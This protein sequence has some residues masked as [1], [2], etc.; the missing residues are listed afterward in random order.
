VRREAGREATVKQLKDRVAVITGGGSGIGA[1]LARACAGAGMRVVVADLD[2]SRAEV[3]AESI[4]DRAAGT[5]AQAV[6]VAVPE[7]V[8][9]LADAVYAAFGAAHLL[10]N[11]AGVSPLGLT[12]ELT[13]ADWAWVFGVNLF[14]VAN[15]IRSFVPRMIAGGE[16]GHV[17][18]TASNAALRA[19]P[20]L[21]AYTASKHAVLGLSD[22]LRLDLASSKIGVS[23]L[24]PGGVSTNIT[25]SMTRL[26]SG[27]PAPEA[28][29]AHIDALVAGSDGP[30]ATPI[31]ADRVATMVMRGV[32][33]GWPYIITSP[34]SKTVVAA[35][36][37]DILEAHEVARGVAP[38][39]P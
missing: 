39:L 5:L 31:E 32:Q 21:G 38:D 18:N 26:P 22:S 28:L 17:V 1:A 16:E 37:D 30:T 35:R 34:G 10:C 33:E 27:A 14:G 13:P 12:W 25:E 15:G 20:R 19:T 23:T 24:C 11:N 9:R 8:D 2:R 4:S 6:D 29:A 7:D 3:V 36:F